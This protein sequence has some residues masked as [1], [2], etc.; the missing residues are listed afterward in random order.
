MYR[1]HCNCN[2]NNAEAN[3][4]EDSCMDVEDA[5]DMYDECGCGFDE[6][7]S[8]F[9]ENP[10]LAQSYVPRQKLNKTFIPS[11]GLKMGTIYPELVRPYEPGQSM[12]EI[13]YL[14][15]RNDIGEGCNG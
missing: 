9:P 15:S 13:E 5:M 1:R 11:V 8:Y 4:Y 3:Y 12:A 6:D 2:N 14:K 10:V 7:F